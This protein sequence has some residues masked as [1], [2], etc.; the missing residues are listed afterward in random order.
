MTHGGSAT[1][2]VKFRVFIKSL[3]ITMNEHHFDGTDPVKVF[4]ILIHFVIEAEKRN[5]SEG[6]AY[7]ALLTYLNGRAK[8]Q[9][10]SM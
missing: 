9:F 4:E 6:Q 1:G 5:M 3:D 2:I 8:S 7:L 10:M